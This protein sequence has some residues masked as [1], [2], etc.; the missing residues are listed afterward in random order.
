W[1]IEWKWDGIR[2]Q[3][4]RRDES[5]ALW[6]RGDERIDDTFPELVSAGQALPPG[7]VLDG[8]ILVWRD[9]RPAPFA[10]LQ[11][12]LGRRSPGK[13]IL[14]QAPAVLIAYDL[15]ESDGEDIRPLPLVE[16]RSRLEAVVARH[17]SARIALSPLVEAAEWQALRE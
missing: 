1:Q 3:L 16:R 8:E 4:I 7:T 5:V 9:D 2:A 17:A 6:S 10:A 14:A 12:R 13:A 11:K 15:L